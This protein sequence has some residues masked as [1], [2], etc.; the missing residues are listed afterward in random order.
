MTDNFGLLHQEPAKL[1]LEMG[2]EHLLPEM[3]LNVPELP[4]TPTVQ[5]VRMG[6][7]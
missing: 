4:E 1:V 7:K 3:R 5:F 2:R 6:M